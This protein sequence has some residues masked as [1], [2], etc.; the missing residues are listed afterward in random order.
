MLQ[1]TNAIKENSFCPL[2]KAFDFGRKKKQN[3]TQ[4]KLDFCIWILTPWK[5]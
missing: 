5:T 2:L 3:T 1:V 4:H